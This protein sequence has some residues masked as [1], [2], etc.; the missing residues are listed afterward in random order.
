MDLGLKRIVERLVLE[1]ILKKILVLGSAAADQTN[2]W[3]SFE[4]IELF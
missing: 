2:R 1:A 4:L 3:A